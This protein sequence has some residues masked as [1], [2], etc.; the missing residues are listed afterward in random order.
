M[1]LFRVGVDHNGNREISDLPP[2]TLQNI[3]RQ[4]P[5]QD[6]VRSTVLSHQFNNMHLN[7]MT[8]D[9]DYAQPVREVALE[10]Q[11]RLILREHLRELNENHPNQNLALDI[12]DC[13]TEV[14]ELVRFES[15][16][17]EWNM[18]VRGRDRISVSVEHEHNEDDGDALYP[19]EYSVHTFF[20]HAEVYRASEPVDDVHEHN[21]LEFARNI[22]NMTFHALITTLDGVRLDDD[23]DDDAV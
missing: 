7:L 10:S 22:I 18:E 13:A 20:D 3:T 8:T 5:A 9:E 14:I 2:E 23:D 12:D 17:F 1:S 4:L 6:A 16:G 15:D 19:P 21:E 11:V